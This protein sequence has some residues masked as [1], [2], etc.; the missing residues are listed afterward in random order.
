MKNNSYLFKQ[1][2]VFNALQI[3]F[4]NILYALAVVLFILPHDLI[5]GGSTGIA[6]IFN[7]YFNINISTF[8]FIFNFI[9][10]ILGA[11]L[12]GKK[13]ALSTLLSTV[14]YPLAL[15]VLQA[16]FSDIILTTNII[17]NTV[18]AGL[19]IGAAIGIIIKCGASSGGMDIPPLVLQKHFGISVAILLYIFDF[20]I[21]IFQASFQ[22]T[23][24]LLFGICLVM[25]YT[26]VIEK[27]IISGKQRAQVQIISEKHNEI[28]REIIE[29]ADRGVTIFKGKTGYLN[30]DCDI[31][32]TVLSN[33]EM[34][35][36]SKIILTI[37][38]NVF[39]IISTVREV[40][41]R[42]FTNRKQYIKNIL[43]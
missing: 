21:L 29:T 14:T 40:S 17:L 15:A 24:M 27:V 28:R 12:L 8:V 2:V 42:G 7:H 10:F 35:R 31:I 37:D 3:I 22:N 34:V 38:P 30:N 18:F 25:I 36:L 19:L 23:E 4:G 1:D 11:F 20:I 33:R 16:M 41:G 9:M 26:Y 39:M 5:T 43:E 32:L 6:L 13:F